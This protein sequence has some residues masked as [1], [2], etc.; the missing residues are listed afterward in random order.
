M[1]FNP[2]AILAAL[3]RHEV[4]YVLIGGLAANAHGVRRTTRDVDVIVE[5]SRGNLE[6][7]ADAAHELEVRSPVIDS[8]MR[9]LDPLDP[10]DLERAA[11]VSLDTS[12]GELDVMNEATGA[13][14]FERL[15]SRAVVVE[16]FG[17][18]VPVAGLDDLIALKRAAG[19][20]VDLR[21]I[22]DLT[23]R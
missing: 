23:D 5:R 4:R 2:A 14:P 17:T 3:E 18:R 20:E 19:R 21:D 10:L 6:R 1:R 7:L 15:A 9:E 8:R 12:E 11:N 16:V 13:P 22:A